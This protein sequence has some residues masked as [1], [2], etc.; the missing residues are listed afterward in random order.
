MPAERLACFD[1]AFPPPPDVR[2]AQQ[3]HAADEFG[4]PAS[5][6]Q[7]LHNPNVAVP[8]EVE[9][10]VRGIDYSV[11]G[12]RSIALENGQTW[13]TAGSGGHVAV[14]AV[15]SLRKGALGGYLLSTKDGVT[16]RVRRVR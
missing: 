7:S 11:G 13:E 16:L 12:T 2:R 15:V 14:G 6:G 9:S 10:R 3:R 4:K 1:A 5:P 8:D